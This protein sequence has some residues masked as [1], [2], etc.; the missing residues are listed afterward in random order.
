MQTLLQ[1]SI[2]VLFDARHLSLH[3]EAPVWALLYLINIVL[4]GLYINVNTYL[5][6]YVPSEI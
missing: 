5:N 6:I 4:T 3:K 2:E 1:K